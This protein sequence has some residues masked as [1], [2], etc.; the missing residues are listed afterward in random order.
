MYIDVSLLINKIIYSL[1]FGSLGLLLRTGF[2][3]GIVLMGA[4]FKYSPT[5]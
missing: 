4:A 5:L 1:G 3:A 2:A